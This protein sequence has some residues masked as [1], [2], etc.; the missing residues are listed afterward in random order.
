L[1]HNG[2]H[3]LVRRSCVV[4]NQLVPVK[5]QIDV[6]DLGHQYERLVG[7]G[8]VVLIPWDKHVATGGEIRLEMVSRGYRRKI[9]ELAAAKSDDFASLSAPVEAPHHVLQSHQ[10]QGYAGAVA[11]DPR[12]ARRNHY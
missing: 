10:Q 8:R 2:Y 7:Q 9:A 3:H 5:P 4:V 11:P 12:H 6:T 1:G